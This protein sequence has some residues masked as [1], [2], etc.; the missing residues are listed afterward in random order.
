MKP[1]INSYFIGV[2]WFLLSLVTSVF[3]DTISKY[4]G[5]TLD[6]SE[7]AFFRFLFSALTLVP[8]IVFYGISTIKTSSFFIH[9]ARGFILFLGIMAWTHGLSYHPLAVATLVS[10]TIPL[11]TLILGYFFL[12]ENIIWQRWVATFIGFTGIAV[13]L[14]VN[15]SEF[16]SFSLILILSAA[17][18][19]GLDVINKIFV[20][21]ET[22]TSMLFYSAVVTA[23]L[24]FVPAIN[25]WQDPSLMQLTLFALLGASANLILFFIL[26]AFSVLDATAIAPYRYL[27][28]LISSL[29][30]FIFFGE[31]IT[32]QI[33]YGALIIIPSTFFIVYSEANK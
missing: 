2:M 33:L 6:P 30:G 18:F 17:G 23:I 4:I 8:F 3:N 9:C 24:A 32:H 5:Q 29:S 20:V 19:A 1:K 22:M 26:K 15:G 7:V 12:N 21:R 13:A 27:E 25:H 16:S 10:F 28:L 31:S 14:G 11:F